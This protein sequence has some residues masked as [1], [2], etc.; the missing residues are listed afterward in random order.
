MPTR[1][2]LDRDALAELLAGE[3]R[4][5]VDQ[6]WDGLYRQL[7][8]P[9]ELTSLPKRLR[10]RL[11][12]EAR[13]ALPVYVEGTAVLLAGLSVVV[14]P[15]SVLALGFFAFLLRGSRRR[16]GEKYAGLRILR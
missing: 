1:Y 7:A 6:V 13:G 5:R 16:E 8:E 12:D 4:Y 11:D 9:S 3:P 14:A 15:I 2:D 10:A